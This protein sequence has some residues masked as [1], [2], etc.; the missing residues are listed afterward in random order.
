M[1]STNPSQLQSFLSY[2]WLILKQA[3]LETWGE[4]K[5]TLRTSIQK[6]LGA[7]LGL[8]LVGT[9]VQFD[10][11][12]VAL[13][14]ATLFLLGLFSRNYFSLPSRMHFEREVRISDLSSK[15]QDR[16]VSAQQAKR[17]AERFREGQDLYERRVDSN[18][19]FEQ[20]SHEVAEW[21]SIVILEL[22]TINPA[23]AFTFESI[24]FEHRHNQNLSQGVQHLAIRNQ[25]G[26]RL[27]KLRLVTGRNF[28]AANLAP[29]F[30]AS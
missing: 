24:G 27:G 30:E 1:Q 19:K 18:T 29:S 10:K 23:D 6:A 28:D 17:L 25:L 26:A 11:E 3:S 12:L 9:A 20:W 7:L 4:I 2:E 14:G 5:R 8:L 21:T 22:N 16:A 15:I 13:G